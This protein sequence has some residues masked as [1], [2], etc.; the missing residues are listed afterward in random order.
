MIKDELAEDPNAENAPLTRPTGLFREFLFDISP[1]NMD[2]WSEAGKAMRVFLIIRAVPMFFLQLLI[3]VV[4][5]TAVK[6]GWSKLLNCI[7]LCIAPV[8][9]TFILDSKKSTVSPFSL[10]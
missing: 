3:P 9:A 10:N 7:Q 6:R 2:D 4:N 8:A 5:Q 1:I